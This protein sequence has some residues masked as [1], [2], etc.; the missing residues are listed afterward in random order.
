M[1]K[2]SSFLD[3]S[4][5]GSKIIDVASGTGDIAKLCSKNTN[6]FCEITCVE[7]NEKMLSMREKKVKRFK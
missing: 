6:N 3:K 2:K 1:E 4:K 7:P 5:K